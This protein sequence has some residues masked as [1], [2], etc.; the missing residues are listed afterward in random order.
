MPGRTPA[1]AVD[2][3]VDPL[4]TALACVARGHITLSPKARSG[5]GKTSGWT[6]NGGDGVGVGGGLRLT[7]QMHFEVLDRGASEGDQRFR[8]ATRAYLYA[9]E[10]DGGELFAAHWHPTGTSHVDFPHWHFG[11]VVLSSTGVFL[12]R[13]HFPSPRVS[14]EHF[15]QLVCQVPGVTPLVTDHHERLTQLEAEF[16]QYKSWAIAPP[17]AAP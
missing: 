4:K 10:T 17:P 9:L 11:S 15:L 7:A 16:D 3:F 13:T 12:E 2:A 14:F 5:G 1:A 6:L 8:V